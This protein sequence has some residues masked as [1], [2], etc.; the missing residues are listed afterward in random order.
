MH[1]KVCAFVSEVSY[2]GKLE[3]REGLELQVVAGDDLLGGAGL[4]YVPVAHQGNTTSS[5]EEA[6]E[7]A[8]LIEA[9]LG[10]K[11]TDDKGKVHK[12]RHR[13]V[14]V[15]SPYNAQVAEIRKVVPDGVNVGTVDKFQGQEAPITI[16]SMASST[17]ED[18][19]RGMDFLYDLHRL[20]VAVSRARS[21]SIVV[22]SPELQRVL[23]RTPSQLRL[24]NAQ[25]WAAAAGRPPT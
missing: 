1:P 20:N 19:P 2:E 15:V 4:R 7:V 5:A 13:H 22:C 10:R 3:S 6:E 9:V 16:Y 17:A 25:C 14:L 21:I 24:A 23:C 12:L 11:W 8:R 18:A